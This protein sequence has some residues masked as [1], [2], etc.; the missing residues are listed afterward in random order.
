M[1]TLNTLLF[2]LISISVF[3]QDQI[4]LSGKVVFA[5]DQSPV[6]F[7]YIRLDG[8]AM[9]TVTD[10]AGNFKLKLEE[11]YRNET[12]IFSYLG[13]ESQRMK[14]SEIKDLLNISIA[15]QETSTLLKEAVVTKK[16]SLDPLKVLKK[17]MSK[18]E[19]NYHTDPVKFDAYYREIVKE[20]EAPIMFADAACNFHY[21]G[22]SS[23]EP[24]RKE[25]ENN[26]AFNNNSTL[27]GFS[28]FGGTRLHRYHFKSR[29][30][31]NDQVK[32]VEARASSNLSKTRLYASI[33]GGPLGL[34]G[35]DRVKF[36][37]YFNDAFKDFNYN[38]YEILE[39]D[40]KWYYQISFESAIDTAQ[41]FGKNVKR[42]WKYWKSR[43]NL[44]SGKIW[45]DQ[46]SMAISKISYSIPTHMKQH[47]CQFR[48]NNIRHFDYKVDIHY[49]KHAGK[50]MIDYIRQED[51]FIYHD[52][53]SDNTIPYR[54]IS[55]MHIKNISKKNVE[56]F[57]K[58]DVF[59][60]S[61]ANQLF[62]YPLTYNG[63]FWIDYQK[64]FPQSVIDKD[65][66]TAMEVDKKLEK[67]FIDKITRDEDMPEPIAEKSDHQY[68][69]L[70][71]TVADPY[72]WLK[73][74]VNP[75]SN[76]KVMDYLESENKYADNYFIP[77][78]KA[79]REIYRELLRGQEQ[80]YTSLPTKSNGYFYYLK[81]KA[82]EDYPRW[83]RK[84]VDSNEEELILDVV[85]RAKNKNYYSASP[86]S[87]NPGNN[88]MAY[89]ENTD[90][91][92]VSTIRFMN[93]AT[94]KDLSDSLS[95]IGDL[96]WKDSTSFFYSVMDK[97]T[98]RTYQIRYHKLGNPYSNDELI[99][100]EADPRFSVSV[101]KSKSKEYF[102][103]S[104]GS[105]NSSETYIMHK[106]NTNNEFKLVKPREKNVTYGMSHYKDKFYIITNLNE[107]NFE[108]MVTDTANYESKYWKNFL[109]GRKGQM[110]T[111]FTVFDN[112]YVV[113]EMKE[114]RN[115][116]RVIDAN[117]M[118][119][120]YIKAK[121]DLPN[122]GLSGNPDFDTDSLQYSYSAPLSLGGVYK[123]HMGTKEKRL[124]KKS[125][126]LLYGPWGAKVE[127]HWAT[128]QDG[129]KIPITVI[130]NKYLKK[131][132]KKLNKPN[133]LYM[134]SYGSYGSSS[135]AG[136]NQDLFS[137]LN[138][139]FSI[140][141]PHIRGGME[142]GYE[143]YEEGK[144]LKKKNTFTDFIACTE[145]LIENEFGAKGEI[146][147]QGG[148]AGGLLMGAVANMRPDL[149]KAVI[150]DVPFVDVVNTMLDDKLPLTTREYEEWGNP[151][152]KE[153]YD[154]I[155]S[156]S[157]YD[158]VKSQD[159]PGMFFFTALNDSRV[160]YWEPAKMVAKLRAL[161]TD[162]N[163]LLL[164]T[165][166]FSGHGGSSGRFSYL[167]ELSYKYALIF[168][169]YAAKKENLPANTP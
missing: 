148:S 40:G 130:Y 94:K 78:K 41:V 108:V 54:A 164:K 132:N 134:T 39:N 64:E 61:D 13:Y 165:D 147:I 49:G 23:K 18:I 114:A 3:G 100:E 105:S 81:Y 82:E 74:T 106:S 36:P 143:W 25:L 48:G 6:P 115:L 102:M 160:G 162:N 32:I 125:K 167:Q 63:D 146:T 101:S 90:G 111:G 30:L 83:Y 86:M 1:K 103:V 154:Y 124:V 45:I 47:V 58:E 19:D 21:G 112:Y 46:E 31:K 145:Y 11:K 85:E 127:R 67:Q 121:A 56:E 22:Y 119:S 5:E 52:T 150:L 53:I 44:M 161:K 55:E 107:K 136:F 118:K 77:L 98:N 97:K 8:L 128:A 138:R 50:Y 62:N 79:Q 59:L 89:A 88:I 43:P 163:V 20:N 153:Y 68:Q 51:E 117:T 122:F 4:Y 120:Y 27:T 137:L 26:G 93:L 116:L 151:N 144:M 9:G 80:N 76:D 42:Q 92:D 129:E 29:T 33:E 139:G 37:A 113:G 60:N 91:S 57:D 96:T 65:I 38:I 71:E 2:L 75:R 166:F 34:L 95:Y 28:S 14:I 159:Y 135:L 133:R 169:L 157:P 141:I 70:G 66:R 10:A 110:I 131:S 35:K 7:G 16:K 104:V 99:F 155:K 17:A 158:N 123:M 140:A 156:Y 72:H 69:H 168:D 109:K 15:L 73:D 126:V 149:Y 12:L 84:K 152:V 87:V 142:M 24:K